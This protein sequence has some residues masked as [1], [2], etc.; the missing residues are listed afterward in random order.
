MNNVSLVPMPPKTTSKLQVKKDSA[1]ESV[2]EPARG[3][4]SQGP[5]GVEDSG[6]TFLKGQQKRVMSATVTPAKK[7][8]LKGKAPVVIFSQITWIHSDFKKDIEGASAGGIA[9]VKNATNFHERLKMWKKISESM[10]GRKVLVL[11]CRALEE[12]QLSRAE[13]GP[14]GVLNEAF[15]VVV[16]RQMR[17]YHQW[18]LKGLRQTFECALKMFFECEDTKTYMDSLFL[19]VE[20]RGA[21]SIRDGFTCIDAEDIEKMFLKGNLELV[22]DIWSPVLDVVDNDFI[23]MNPIWGERFLKA[24]ANVLAWLV[25]FHMKSDQPRNNSKFNPGQYILTAEVVSQAIYKAD[26]VLYS[27]NGCVREWPTIKKPPNWNK[28]Q[29]VVKLYGALQYVSLD[30]WQMSMALEEDIETEMSKKQGL[31]KLPPKPAR[32]DDDFDILTHEEQCK[33]VVESCKVGAMALRKLEEQAGQKARALEERVNE[34]QSLMTEEIVKYERLRKTIE[35]Q[36]RVKRFFS[37]AVKM[38]HEALEEGNVGA[39]VSKMLEDEYFRGLVN[40]LKVDT[41]ALQGHGT[42]GVQSGLPGSNHLSMRAGGMFQNHG[43][44]SGPQCNHWQ[45]NGYQNGPQSFNM[46]PPG[47]VPGG[48]PMGWYPG[49]MMQMA[50]YG[51]QGGTTGRTPGSTH[52]GVPGT[53]SEGSMMEGSS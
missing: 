8:R 27:N 37:D 39:W 43:Q 52:G 12:K 4:Q 24:T 35:W 21:K 3:L 29:G 31:I 22:H 46:I 34:I 5:I 20:L 45:F 25:T 26:E 51:Q 18:L 17:I 6:V 41:E 36:L 40:E 48:F 47:G 53:S 2:P 9:A 33:R 44:F 16:V 10:D 7:A 38:F 32:M 42:D 15:G 49:V 11:A 30:E 1:Q 19:Q 28:R 13:R 23:C 50:G 14:E